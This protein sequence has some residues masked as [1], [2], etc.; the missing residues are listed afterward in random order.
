MLT[1]VRDVVVG[2]SH[3]AAGPS[4][5]LLDEIVREGARRMLAAASEAEVAAYTDAHAHEL[6]EQGSHGRWSVTGTPSR[7]SWSLMRVVAPR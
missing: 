4:L 6:C 2:D 1:A 7:G 5:S 3:G